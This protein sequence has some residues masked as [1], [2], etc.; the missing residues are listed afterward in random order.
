VA[1]GI[2]ALL[3]AFDEAARAA[4][5]TS[6]LPSGYSSINGH[7]LYRIAPEHPLMIRIYR[8]QYAGQGGNLGCA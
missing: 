5:S 8:D 2:A 4:C 6:P 7:D 1:R 3:V